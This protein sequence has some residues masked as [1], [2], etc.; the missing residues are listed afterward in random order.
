M[1]RLVRRMTRVWVRVDETV[2]LAELRRA[3]VA[4]GYTCTAVHPRVVLIRCGERVHMRAWAVRAAHVPGDARVLLEFRR[5]RG[6]GLEFKRHFLRLREALAHVAAEAPPDARID[7]IAPPLHERE[8][9]E[10]RERPMD[11]AD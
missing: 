11:I 1:Q 7:L 3:L 2:A 5:S 6:C 9:D 10:E 8:R 4:H